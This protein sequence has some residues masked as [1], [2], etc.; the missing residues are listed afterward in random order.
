MWSGRAGSLTGPPRLRKALCQGLHIGLRT[1]LSAAR[2]PTTS[3]DTAGCLPADVRRAGGIGRSPNAAHHRR[4]P[5]LGP[6]PLPEA[7]RSARPS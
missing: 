4:R 3:P 1:F 2:A 6:A 5:E 7:L